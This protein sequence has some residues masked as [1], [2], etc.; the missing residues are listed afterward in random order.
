MRLQ[1]GQFTARG[2]RRSLLT[3]AV[4]PVI[5]YVARWQAGKSPANWF[6]PTFPL[7]HGED[8]NCDRTLHRSK[9]QHAGAAPHVRI[10]RFG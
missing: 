10:R 4:N 5:G 9:I 7:S 3:T 6:I 1:R 2:E 8:A